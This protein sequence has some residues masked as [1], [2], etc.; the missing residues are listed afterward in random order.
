MIEPL[1]S[2]NGDIA[3]LSFVTHFGKER[4]YEMCKEPDGIFCLSYTGLSDA[5]K[6]YGVV[7]SV[8]KNYVEVVSGDIVYR[9]L[10]GEN[11]N[12]TDLVLLV[13]FFDIDGT[14]CWVASSKDIEDHRCCY[15]NLDIV[16]KDKI[17]ERLRIEPYFGKSVLIKDV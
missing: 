9:A 13:E 16:K 3:S 14:C 5:K 15:I 8:W 7:K 4:V 6:F 12:V 1:L 11:L 2:H 17:V 10:Y